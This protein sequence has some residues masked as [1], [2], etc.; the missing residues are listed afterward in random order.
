MQFP[1]VYARWIRDNPPF[2]LI[3][4]LLELPATNP[5]SDPAHLVEVRTLLTDAI[6]SDQRERT[7]ARVLAL[8][9]S[10]HTQYEIATQ[11]HMTVGAVESL[12]Y[13]H[14]RKVGA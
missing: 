7:L 5:D 10:G 8:L 2:E 14:R 11:L 3:P 13:R 12:L 6:G 4:E 1:R 9:T